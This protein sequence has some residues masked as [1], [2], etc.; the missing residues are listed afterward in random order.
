MP[1]PDS[2]S[3][4][5]LMEL[6]NEYDKYIQE[7]ND[8]DRYAD[9]WMPVC[10]NEF[11]D[12]EWNEK[13]KGR[14]ENTTKDTTVGD[15]YYTFHSDPEHGWL[16]VGFSEIKRLGIEKDISQHSYRKGER[17]FLEEDSDAGK[18]LNAKKKLGEIVRF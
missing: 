17:V 15:Y 16:E 2:I 4:E 8:D 14:V 6:L 11:Y 7:A 1:I 10:I 18:F 12:N 5:E 13:K 9:G 3:K